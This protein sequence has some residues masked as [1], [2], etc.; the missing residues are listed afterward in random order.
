MNILKY[1]R[2]NSLGN[3]RDHVIIRKLNL[4]LMASI[5]DLLSVRIDYLRKK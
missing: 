1:K 3:I 2:N 4:F 5:G